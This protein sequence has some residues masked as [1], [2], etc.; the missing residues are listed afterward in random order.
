MPLLT[1]R[2]GLAIGTDVSCPERQMEKAHGKRSNLRVMSSA[3][4]IWVA[5]NTACTS[6]AGAQK[7]ATTSRTLRR[8]HIGLRWGGRNLLMG[9]WSL[10]ET[11]WFCICGAARELMGASSRVRTSGCR[12][13]CAGGGKPKLEN[14]RG[15][16]S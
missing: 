9:F 4:G 5:Y 15:S 11:L 1:S 10:K 8:S 16:T 7:A 13:Q 14:A 2:G 12:I 6:L 3:F